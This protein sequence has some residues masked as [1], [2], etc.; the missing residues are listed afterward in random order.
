[1]SRLKNLYNILLANGDLF[2]VF[3]GMSGNW[4][5]DRQ[6]FT[7]IQTDLESQVK[8]IDEQYID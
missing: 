3:D 8:N 6:H 2:E 1:M 4:E 7:Q 5:E